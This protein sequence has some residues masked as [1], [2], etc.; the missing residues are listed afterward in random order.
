MNKRRSSNRSGGGCFGALA[1]ILTLVFLLGIGCVFVGFLAVYTDPQLNPIAEFRPIVVPTVEPTITPTITPQQLP[2][3]FTPAPTD[4]PLPTPT[5]RASSTP[6]PTETP[7]SLVTPPTPDPRATATPVFPYIID[8]KHPLFLDYNVINT[9][10]A[11][12]FMGVG[13]QIFDLNNNPQTGL[14]IELGGT[15]QGLA[16]TGLAVSGTAQNYGP[17]GYELPIADG[18]IA[19]AK[20][21]YVQVRDQSG[22]AVSDKIYFDTF[23]DCTKNLILINFLQTR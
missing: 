10:L 13:G 19:S 15:I 16:V 4:T 22:V 7:F 8:A 1:N 5:L 11:C 6:F 18:P 20:T 3:T 12:G 14:I 17:S 2:P 21:L 9:S 23:D